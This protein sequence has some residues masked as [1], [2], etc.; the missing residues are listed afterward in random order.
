MFDP[1]YLSKGN[2]SCALDVQ[3]VSRQFAGNFVLSACSFCLPNSGLFG[4]IGPSGGGKS[5]LLKILAGVDLDFTGEIHRG[6]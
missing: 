5:V 6:V 4:L 1:P 2:K 3:S